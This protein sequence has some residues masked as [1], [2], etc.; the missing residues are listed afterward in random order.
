MEEITRHGFCPLCN[1]DRD[2]LIGKDAFFCLTCSGSFTKE[3]QLEG[4]D[5]KI[6][7]ESDDR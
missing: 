5:N 7:K 6:K 1:E 4:L 2:I 3:E